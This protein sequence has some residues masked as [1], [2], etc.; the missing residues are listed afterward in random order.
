MLHLL[1][2]GETN[3]TSRLYLATYFNEPCSKVTV[4]LISYPR[5]IMVE[6]GHWIQKVRGGG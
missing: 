4:L 5:F 2:S 3:S 1:L 6:I